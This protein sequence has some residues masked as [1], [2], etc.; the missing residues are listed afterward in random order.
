VRLYATLRQ[1]ADEERA[2]EIP[3]S[4]GD[5]VGEVVH[6]LLQRKPGL[7]G[8]VIDRDGRLVK[9]VSVFLNGRDIRHLDGL[10]TT[11]NGEAEISIFPPVAGG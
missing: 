11:V 1:R 10:A 9:Y 4:P 6:E 2:V 8:H 3:W 7:E 5:T